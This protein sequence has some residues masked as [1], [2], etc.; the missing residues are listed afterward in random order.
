MFLIRHGYNVQRAVCSAKSYV[1]YNVCARWYWMYYILMKLIEL[2]IESSGNNG[3]AFIFRSSFGYSFNVIRC[4]R[5]V[6]HSKLI[7]KIQCSIRWTSHCTKYN[8][9]R[10]NIQFQPNELDFDSLHIVSIRYHGI[11][12]RV[13]FK[14][15]RFI[16]S[17]Y[18]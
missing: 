3:I 14:Q 11:M 17:K 8:V 1:R 10:S 2:K 12:S 18:S 6:L 9:V 5:H 13:S 4:W 15:E 7:H 16:S